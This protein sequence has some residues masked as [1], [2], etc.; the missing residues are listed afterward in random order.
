MTCPVCESKNNK[1][2]GEAE[3]SRPNGD[4]MHVYECTECEVIWRE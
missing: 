2:H 4:A 3:F 1:D